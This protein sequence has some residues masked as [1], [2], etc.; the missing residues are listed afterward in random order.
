MSSSHLLLSCCGNGEGVH[1]A[2]AF[3]YLRWA[4]PAARCAVCSIGA[5]RVLACVG[6]RPPPGGGRQQVASNPAQ[7]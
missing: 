5:D 1:P 4:S 3:E 2:K 7:P 6:R